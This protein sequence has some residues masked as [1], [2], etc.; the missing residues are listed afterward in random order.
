L[1]LLIPPPLVMLM[2][3]AAMWGIAFL[4]PG[5]SLPESPRYWLPVIIML[6]GIA[7][8][9]AG[10]WRFARAGTTVNPHS[11]A[12][13]TALVTGG[14]YNF[15]RNPMYLGMALIL[16]AMVVKTA[17]PLTLIGLFAFVWFINRF[18]IEP[19]EAFLR[20]R[21]GETFAEYERRVRRWL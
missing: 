7:I 5:Y 12:K 10:I 18:Q 3:L 1:R 6:A 4:L 11:P 21:Y 9:V 2:A 13:G 17:Q 15:T 20:E 14:I 16:L 19:E 8:I